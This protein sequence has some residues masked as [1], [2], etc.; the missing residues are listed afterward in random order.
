MTLARQRYQ[1][2]PGE[3]ARFSSK[4][5]VTFL[6]DAMHAAQRAEAE[7]RP[8]PGLESLHLLG[9]LW[10]SCR[11]DQKKAL[12]DVGQWLERRLTKADV[13]T[14]VQER[15]MEDIGWVKREATAV[16]TSAAIAGRTEPRETDPRGRRE[17]IKRTFGDDTE[18]L[19]LKRQKLRDKSRK[20]EDQPK[21]LES[22]TELPERFEAL[23]DDFILAREALKNHRKRLKD[24]KLPR[25]KAFTLHPSHADLTE[26]ARGLYL[27]TLNTEGF[28][29]FFV[30]AS[31]KGGAA[32]AFFV[33]GTRETP[34]G[35]L[36]LR[37]VPA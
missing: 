6:S 19:R 35:R 13:K 28:L 1:Q 29:D 32:V 26:L 24:E 37:I 27:S 36:A 21:P 7:G 4:S 10:S 14:I 2:I 8:D 5:H 20:L 18:G 23:F 34:Q 16:S 9:C 15:I 22:A 3:A 30:H 12:N 17:T 31:K 25:D 11:T 33:E